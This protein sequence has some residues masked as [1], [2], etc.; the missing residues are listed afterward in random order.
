MSKK[1]A[2]VLSGCGVFDGS[3]IY[4]GTV[5]LL[6]LDRA[7]AQ[8]DC[9]AP[10]VDFK[11][12][13]H[14]TGAQTDETRNVLVESARLARGKIADIVALKA[15]DY[16][17]VVFP[18]GFGAANN[19]SD[20]ATKGTDCTVNG[21]VDRVIDDFITA[22]KPIGAMCIAPAMLARSLANH[23]VT[24]TLTLGTDAGTGAKI[25]AMGGITH[26]TATVDAIV[27]DEA[28]K[29]VTTPAYMLGPGIKDI[30]TGIERLVGAVLEIA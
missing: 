16:D 15:A 20:F 27:V 22:K 8:V 25:E 17:A 7:G 19:L 6:A 13:N 3:E 21:E 11:V 4:E 30:A 12:K 14:L 9:F 18:G 26:K 24:A 2:V 28:R 23:N 5:T 10:N 1:V 29:I